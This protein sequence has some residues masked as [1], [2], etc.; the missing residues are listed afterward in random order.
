MAKDYYEILGVGRSASTD[1]IKA[2]FRKLAHQ[3]HPDKAGGNA[4]KFKEANVA[5]QVLSSAEKRRQYDQYGSSFEQPG[6]PGGSSGFGGVRDFSDFAEAFRSG[7]ASFDV[8]DLSDLFGGLGE[9]FGGRGGTKR[10]R[11]SGGDVQVE[12]TLPLR[13]A[14]FGTTR[15]LQLGRERQCP[16]CSGS[17][18]QPGSSTARC[19]ACGGR[20]QVVRE[21]GLGFGMPSVCA[22]CGGL[23]SRPEK[24]CRD[25]HGAGVSFARETITVKIPAGIDDGQA[26]RIAGAGQAARG[27]A[28]GDLYVRVQVAPD[29]RFRRTGD[30]LETTVS[31]SFPTAALGGTVTLETLD[32]PTAVKIPE[33]TPSG[34]VIR[35]RG[36]GVPNVQGRGRGDVLVRVQVAI[37]AKLTR[38][39]RQLLEELRQELG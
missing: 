8:G 3:Y 12:I 33:G 2:A 14:V 35:L 11:R 6:Q 34:K 36:K 23:G 1:E 28:A 26:I 13:Q 16:S 29:Q 5:Y 7:G 9:I 30:N 24:P 27:T 21:I 31:V 20:G 18:A 22:E 37:P 32:G 39:Q 19:R 10:A 17:G 15:E 38:R 4:E 25:C